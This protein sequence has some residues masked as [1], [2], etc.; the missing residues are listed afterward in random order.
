MKITTFLFALIF[1]FIPLILS[2]QSLTGKKTCISFEKLKELQLPDVSILKIESLPS[3]TNVNVPFCRVQG[4]ISKEINFELLVPQQWNGRFLMSGNG[5]FAGSIQNKL[6]S[7]V[8]EGFAVAGTDTGHQ[9]FE[10]LADWA[11]NNMERQLNFGRLAIHRTTVVSKSILNTLYCTYPRYSYFLGCSRGGG[12]AMVEAQF[13]PDDFNGIVAGAPAFNW[14][15]FGAQFIRGSQNNYPN[16]A[17]VSKPVITTENLK[18]LQDYVLRQCDNIDGVSD[19]IINDP[20]DCTIDFSALPLCPNN[21]PG[22][23]CF[24]QE[25]I[26]AIKSIYS[27]LLVN[28]EQV[29]PGFPVGLEAEAGSWDVWISGTSP[30]MQKAPSLQY[31]FGTNMFKYLVYNNS[32]WDYSTYDFKNFFEE[33]KYSS[34]YLDATQTDYSGLKKAKGKM[35]MY[36]GWNDPALSA[37][38]TIQHYEEAAQKDKDLP[39]YIRLF[40]LPGVLHCNGGTGPDNIDWV[41]LIQDWVENEKAPERIVLS[42]L[43]NGKTIMTRPVF[44]FPKMTIYTGRGDTNLEQNFEVKPNKK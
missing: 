40:L 24:T 29:Y 39:S 2:G 23:S 5:G 12:Q 30:F 44:P 36:H 32:T 19:R 16:P 15:A 21:K 3:D 10:L 6:K 41:K 42:K 26:K 34:A 18:L 7:Y 4:K 20:R 33:T 17:D 31:M 38:A 22:V 11:L 13:Y 37:Y 35:I 25:Q 28:N 9:G 14:P 1:G 8:N 43:D 27:P